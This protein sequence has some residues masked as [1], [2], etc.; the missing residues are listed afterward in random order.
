MCLYT[1][2]TKTAAFCTE[3]K[4]RKWVTAYKIVL[5]RDEGLFSAVLFHKYKSGW[6]DSKSK[7]RPGTYRSEVNRGIHV[8]AQLSDAKTALGRYHSLYPIL[9]YT[10][11]PVHCLMEDLM[12]VGGFTYQHAAF[13]K[14]YVSK[15][16]YRKALECSTY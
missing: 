10:I 16:A 13:K 11:L 9:T 12:G 7:M 1:D 14:V 5:I 8:Y 4:R 2:R 3:N 6:V 15:T